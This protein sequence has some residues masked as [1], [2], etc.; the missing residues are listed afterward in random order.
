MD[1]DDAIKG[2]KE[3]RAFGPSGRPV[4]PACG[5]PTAPRSPSLYEERTGQPPLVDDLC[6]NCLLIAIKRQG[7]MTPKQLAEHRWRSASCKS[8]RHTTKMIR[9]ALCQYCYANQCLFLN[10]VPDPTVL[11]ANK[12][13]VPLTQKEYV[14]LETK[15]IKEGLRHAKR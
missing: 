15:K 12:E 7:D 11:E 9:C 10:L 4:C 2:V 13:Y 3:Q 8:C 14:K 5:Q 1:A 6:S